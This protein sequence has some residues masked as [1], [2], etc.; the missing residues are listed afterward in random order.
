MVEDTKGVILSRECN[1]L[2]SG[3]DGGANGSLF[4]AGE[5]EVLSAPQMKDQL[6]LAKVQAKLQIKLA[7]ERTEQVRIYLEVR[8]LE[9]ER[10]HERGKQIDVASQRRLVPPFDELDVTEYFLTFEKVAESLKW[11]QDV[12]AVLLQSV[13]VGKA[14]L[15]YTALSVDECKQ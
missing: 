5:Q 10:E 12:W 2:F 9:N 15:A 3:E 1:R 7:K 6:E 8:K 4:M 13:L 14:Q 11:P